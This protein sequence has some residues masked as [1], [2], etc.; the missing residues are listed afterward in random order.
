[1]APDTLH[2][3]EDD[4]FVTLRIPKNQAQPVRDY[5][6]NHLQDFPAPMRNDLQTQLSSWE[7]GSSSGGGGTQ[8]G[9]SRSSQ[10]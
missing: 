5:M 8:Q 1:M 6:R 9:G 2:R 7:L 4:D 10:R 3:G